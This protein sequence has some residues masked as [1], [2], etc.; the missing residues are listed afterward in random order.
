MTATSSDL[1][2]RAAVVRI[3]SSEN[4]GDLPKEFKTFAKANALLKEMALTAP[5][6]RTYD[7]TDFEIEFA[8]GETYKGRIDL[9]FSHA[10]EARIIEE[11]VLHHLNFYS[12]RVRA[13]DLPNHLDHEGYI[14][15]VVEMGHRDECIR[16]LE[17]YRIGD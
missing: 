12:G 8:D 13:G 11:H 2:V 14:S 1:M 17:D 4:R 6:D 16:F 10:G 7:K 15:M 9:K 5:K 3:L